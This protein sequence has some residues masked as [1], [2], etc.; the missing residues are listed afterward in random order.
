MTSRNRKTSIKS[1]EVYSMISRIPIGCVSTYGDIAKALGRPKSARAVGSILGR[2]PDPVV[3][4]CHRVVE[5]NG[6]IGGYSLGIQMKKELLRKEGLKFQNDF[7]R[8]LDLHRASL[9]V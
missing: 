5:H 9:S 2:N 4:P 7:I 1:E 6:R 8:D 3:V